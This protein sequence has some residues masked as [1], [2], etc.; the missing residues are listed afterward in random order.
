MRD[1]NRDAVASQLRAV[2]LAALA[3]GA[4]ATSPAQAHPAT[5][6]L[7][8][9]PAEL[10]ALARQRGDGMFLFQTDIGRQVLYV[11][12]SNGARL[13][14]LDVTDP[15]HVTVEGLVT[16]DA[17]EP[18][19]VVSMLG[20]RAALVRYRQTREEAVLDLRDA[21]HPSLTAVARQSFQ[22][23]IKRLGN[24]GV[25]VSR[26]A[27]ASPDA[28]GPA[29][30]TAIIDTSRPQAVMNRYEVHAVRQE[31][32]NDVTGT[33]FLLSDDGLYL[34]RRLAVERANDFRDEALRNDGG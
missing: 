21:L 5:N 1:Q 34:I 20:A 14:I 27:D 8:V 2:A 24:D 4:A 29:F 26:Q 33:T 16:V 23:S 10:P 25:T 18:F 32:T 31:L 6:L 15:R 30:D 11:E 22:G 13:A 28:S 19:D 7:V 12:Q 17:P 9:A 3:I